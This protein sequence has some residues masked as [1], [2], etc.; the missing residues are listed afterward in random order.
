MRTFYTKS[1]ALWSLCLVAMASLLAAPTMAQTTFGP[2]SASPALTLGSGA[3]DDGYNGTLGSMGVSTVA[4]SGVTGSSVIDIE[5]DVNINHTWVG[6]LVLKLVSPDGDIL[7]LVSRPGYAETVDDG[8]GCCGLNAD[9]ASSVLTFTDLGTNDAEAMNLP[10]TGTYYPNPGITASPTQTFASLFGGTMNGNW[11]LYMGDAGSGDI[12]T[13]NSWAIRI[14]TVNPLINVYKTVAV[15]NGNG[16]CSDDVEPLTTSINVNPGTDVCYFYT[17]ENVGDVALGLHDLSD[18]I[19][20]VLA[21]GMVFDLQ[22]TTAGVVSYGPVTINATVTNVATWTAYNAGPIDVATNTASATVTVV[23]PPANDLCA[24]AIPVSCGQVV[25]GT[26][27]GATATA[28]PAGVSEGVWYSLTGTGGNIT[29]STC[30]GTTW[31]SEIVVSK[32]A[33]GALTWVGAN[34]DNCGLQSSYTFAS[35]PGETYYIYVADYNTVIDGGTNS[36]AFQLTIACAAPANDLCA[37]AIAVSCGDV[38]TGN[39]DAATATGAP[40][41]PSSISEG[42]WYSFAGTGEDVTVSTCGAADFDTEISVSSGSCGALTWIGGN[43]DFSGCAGATSEYTFPSAIGTT[44]YIYVADYSSTVGAGGERGT[45]DLYVTCAPPVEGCN[46]ASADGLYP[47][48]PTTPDAG[49]AVTVIADDQYEGSEYSVIT[50]IQSGSDY[51]FTHDA[52]SYI[53]VRQGTVTGPIV[54]EG[55]S[56]LTITAAAAT[57]LFVHWTLDDQCTVGGISTLHETTVQLVIPPTCD[58]TAGTLTADAT[59]VTLSAGSATIS[60]TQ[61][62]APFVPSGY[63]VVYVLT[64]GPGLVIVGASPTPSFN[65]TTAGDYTIHTLVY[66]PADQATLL[67]STTG[68]DVDALLIQGGGSLCGALDVTGAPITV[69]DEVI[70]T[71]DATAGTLTA[72]ATPVALS[73]GSATISATQGTA[74]F[75]PSGYSVVYVL[76]SGSGLVIVG[77][78]PTPSFNVTTAGDYTIHTLVY[79]PADQATLLASTTGFDV[80]ALLI[81]G[82]GSLCGALDV[83]GAPITVEDEVIVGI[84]ES[85]NANLSVYPNPSNGQFIIGLNGVEGKVIMNIVDMMGRNVYTQAVNVSGTFRQ[86]ID[87]NIAKGSYLLQIITD[88]G[89]AT[90]KVEL[91]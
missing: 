48:S 28:A 73:A 49:G 91:M 60:A 54:G 63:S 9:W 87:L 46:N 36:G 44:Y 16:D 80:D 21:T 83:T 66:D 5:V 61:G 22:P 26:T 14:T 82:G 30:T 85:L 86:A 64:S 34:D 2:F 47:A 50:G 67:A 70:V 35:T 75:V 8:T 27:L 68:F 6:D 7:T 18:D 33:C 79:D 3:G 84:N 77:A 37:G 11:S 20:G 42:I 24:D 57:N 81:Q 65:V 4:V 39:T 51:V 19:F 69:E 89:V 17:V 55:Y 32:G 40:T 43:D 62:T 13:L 74:P 59:P 31:D 72:D 25:T 52:G 29:V 38:V 10:F 23:L 78:S 76:T 1:S 56:P 71:C 15:E 53:T 12:A 90:R 58:A 45:F 88:N 41:G